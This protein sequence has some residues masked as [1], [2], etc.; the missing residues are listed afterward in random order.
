MLRLR[1]RYVVLPSGVKL[2]LRGSVDFNGKSLNKGVLIAATVVF[3]AGSLSATGFG[4]AIPAGTL[5][6]A[7]VDGPQRVR[8]NRP[9]QGTP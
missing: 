4:F 3:G 1:Y 2:P 7:A 6:Q 5:F 8:V 9:V